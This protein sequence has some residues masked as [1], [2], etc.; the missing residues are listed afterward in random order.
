MAPRQ[1]EAAAVVLGLVAGVAVGLGTGDVPD[2]PESAVVS[3]GTPFYAVEEAVVAEG[4]V[5][6]PL[7]RM[8]VV[9]SP[10]GR[11]GQRLV[12]VEEVPKTPQQIAD[13]LA[14][15][16]KALSEGGEAPRKAEWESYAGKLVAGG[17]SLP[18]PK[19]DP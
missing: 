8:E 6:V 2:R 14:G 18:P 9:R 7:K 15:C 4:G 11:L 16:A 19:D 1:R 5:S 13:A 12:V 3:A 17:I 10:D